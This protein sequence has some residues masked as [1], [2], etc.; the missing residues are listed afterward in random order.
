[1]E[2][3]VSESNLRESIYDNLE[4]QRL[5]RKKNRFRFHFTAFLLFYYL[6]LPVVFNSPLIVV[7]N[8]L[9]IYIVWFYVFSLFI[10][11]WTI[12]WFYWKYMRILDQRI[13]D[14]KKEI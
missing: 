1:M 3:N 11:T 2:G 6:I 5:I 13:M 10:I 8:N 12:G 4:L 9:Y 14:L 7:K